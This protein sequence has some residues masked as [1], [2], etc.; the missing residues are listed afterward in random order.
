MR[1]FL[2][3]EDM[4]VVG[5][6][7]GMVIIKREKGQSDIIDLYIEDDETYFYKQTFAAFW[8]DDLI[9]VATKAKEKADTEVIFPE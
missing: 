3:R 6:L 9:A 1:D 7:F 4:D 2:Q 8:L 5:D